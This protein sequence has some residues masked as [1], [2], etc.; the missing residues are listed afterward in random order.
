MTIRFAAISAVLL[1]ALAAVGARADIAPSRPEYHAGVQ[2][3]EA[4]PYPVV[5]EVA[6]GSPAEKAGVR[7]GDRLLALNGGYARTQVPFYSF[8]RGL[9][10]QKDSKLQLILLR[11]DKEVLVIVVPRTISAR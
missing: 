7:K 5:S 8:A 10:G 2:I 4:Q 3:Q 1:S 9:R 6:T 11:N